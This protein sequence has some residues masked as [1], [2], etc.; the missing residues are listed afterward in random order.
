M[1]TK[2][3]AGQ[4]T[5]A[6]LLSI[7]PFNSGYLLEEDALTPMEDSVTFA[8]LLQSLQYYTNPLKQYES[9]MRII[10]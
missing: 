1:N 2:L 9:D 8:A 5:N 3:P 7:M 6:V 4:L 10:N